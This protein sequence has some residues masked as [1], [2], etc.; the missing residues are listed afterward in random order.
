MFCKR[1]IL[2]LRPGSLLS[3]FA[4]RSGL[5]GKL[6]KIGENKYSY[7]IF[8]N[9]GSLEAAVAQYMFLCYAT[10]LELKALLVHEPVS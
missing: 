10:F 3:G 2:A 8:L 1:V 6:P 7:N 4:R 9:V 5:D